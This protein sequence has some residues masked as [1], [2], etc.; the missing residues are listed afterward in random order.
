MIKF[1]INFATIVLLLGVMILFLPFA[2]LI[3]ILLVIDSYLFQIKRKTK[4]G[5]KEMLKNQ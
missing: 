2:I 3:N 4:S 1:W 5:I